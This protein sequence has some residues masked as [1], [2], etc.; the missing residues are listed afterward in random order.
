MKPKFLHSLFLLSLITGTLYSCGTIRKLGT[1]VGIKIEVD[2]SE[3]IYYGHR[4]KL[5]TYM[6]YDKGFTKEITGKSGLSYRIKGGTNKKERITAE[7]YPTSFTGD[8]IFAEVTY[9]KK[10]YLF[11]AKKAFPFNYK[12]N[13]VLD[14][15]G[16]NG[17]SGADGGNGGTSILF[18]S[19]KDGDPGLDGDVGDNGHDLTMHAYKNPNNDFFYIRLTDLVTSNSYYYKYKDLGYPI[20]IYSNGGKGGKGGD[21][22]NGGDGKDGV[23]TEKKTKSPGDGGNGGIGGNGGPGGNGGAVYVFLHPSA[24]VL[25]SKITLFNFGADGG[26][27][28]PGGKAG[29]AGDP[30]DG[31]NEALNGVEGNSGYPGVKGENGPVILITIEEFDID[32]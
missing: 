26:E 25:Q 9:S 22:G 31:Q 12:G 10:N 29:K 8:T 5:R 13:L 23:I 4:F 32:F 6:V 1:P 21:G 28:G 11:T 7:W 3:N 15:N 27:A 18:R 20:K 30:E 2:E 24:Q 17:S 19:G 16:Q 14:F